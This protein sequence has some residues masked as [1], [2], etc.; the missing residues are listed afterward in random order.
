MLE[1]GLGFIGTATLDG[2]I[3]ATAL[4]LHWKNAIVYKYSASEERAR[5]VNASHAVVWD[6]MRWGC[7]HGFTLFDLG[8]SDLTNEGL[9]QFKRGWGS[10]ESDLVYVR[11]GASVNDRASD[12]PG[13]LQRLK[14]AVSKIPL[15]ILKF[16]GRKIYAH[17]G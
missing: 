13:M 17:I 4:F 1:A 12:A 10:Q 9:L 11:C 5:S 6:A 8:R 3:L 14:P 16:V 7:E 15:P 2:R